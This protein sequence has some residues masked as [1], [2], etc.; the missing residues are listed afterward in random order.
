MH[1]NWIETLVGGTVLIVAIIFAIF[2]FRLN[3][4]SSMRG[5]SLNADFQSVQGVALGTPVKLSGI[6]IGEVKSINLDSK[7]FRARLEFTINQGIEIPDD[8]VVTI[9][10]EGLLGGPYVRILPGGSDESFKPGDRF[11]YSQGPV[12]I[13][14]L[15]G[16][17]FMA[18]PSSA[19]GTTAAATS[20]TKPSQK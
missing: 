18:A 6:A 16:K 17:V 20:S 1:R 2:V 13:A 11:Q 19:T 15:L 10:N 7:S 4:N 12:D 5:Y 3:H 9:S 14:D 8:S